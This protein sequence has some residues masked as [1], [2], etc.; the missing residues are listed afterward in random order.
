[1][2][3]GTNGSVPTTGSA[4][5]SDLQQQLAQIGVGGGGGTRVPVRVR[6]PHSDQ[7]GGA[8]PSW[9]GGGDES[10]VSTLLNDVGRMSTG[11][12]VKLQRALYLAGYYRG[13]GDSPLGQPP[14]WGYWEP[15]SDGKAYQS[16][17]GEAVGTFDDPVS[18]KA[19]Y[20]GSTKSLDELLAERIAY[21]REDAL[22]Q[23]SVGA[24]DL[25]TEV[26]STVDPATVEMAARAHA[27]DF[28]GRDLSPGE[29]QGI[30]A[31][32]TSQD[33]Q[34]QLAKANASQASRLGVLGQMEMSGSDAGRYS[35]PTMVTKGPPDGTPG[36]GTTV[37]NG[38]A[39]AFGGIVTQGWVGPGQNGQGDSSGL[40]FTLAVTSEN[41]QALQ[42]WLQ[43]QTGDGKLIERFEVDGKAV[44]Q[45]SMDAEAEAKAKATEQQG[46]DAIAANE[47][48][49]QAAKYLGMPER[50]TVE[51]ALA[52][53]GLRWGGGG[54]GADRT[55]EGATGERSDPEKMRAFLTLVDHLA[56]TDDNFRRVADEIASGSTAL[57]TGPDTPTDSLDRST[58]G[59]VGPGASGDPEWEAKWADVQGAAGELQRKWQSGHF[60]PNVA[61]PATGG[62]QAETATGQVG[63]TEGFFGALSD[64]QGN[65]LVGKPAYVKVKLREG[66]GVPD[67]A[68]VGFANDD[69]KDW[70]FLDAVMRKD[71]RDPYAWNHGG[72]KRGAYGID[73]S[74]YRRIA[75]QRNI[76]NAPTYS[77]DEQRRVAKAYVEDLRKR[78][79]NDW[80]GIAHA[81]IT[82]TDV[83]DRWHAGNGDVNTLGRPLRDSI[84]RIYTNMMS[85]TA[86]P[87]I[88]TT[89][90][91]VFGVN[92]EKLSQFS[93][94]GYSVVEDVNPTARAQLETER[95]NATE[96][97]AY[98]V[99]QAMGDFQS[100]IR[101]G[102]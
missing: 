7:S 97:Q 77:A 34:A 19:G 56:A 64:A 74:T 42:E 78:Y 68:K 6:S 95:R 93:G 54:D 98:G 96:G 65:M 25:G 38:I 91:D 76:T 58:I 84:D 30:V 44:D 13:R 69:E 62:E 9:L 55:I 26:I 16:L 83:V 28:L 90:G 1:M 85:G 81:W 45:A 60:G 61:A 32:V 72:D 39:G 40:S 71:S 3:S 48:G 24:G 37:A 89:F 70:R 99:A 20:S 57:V 75:A 21:H 88:D 86:A 82:S 14:R 73:E 15:G 102:V 22:K 49:A 92:G 51:Q 59:N 47:A 23:A 8:I 53:A 36:N 94:G 17:I 11:E 79:G 12:I 4:L 18:G 101:G 5:P 41:A 33:F 35:M 100:M 43:A 31:T 10:D 67:F 2:G 29:V 27:K 80:H 87:A 46:K 63:Q 52:A 50:P 66:A